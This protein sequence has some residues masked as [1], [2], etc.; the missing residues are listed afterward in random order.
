[1]RENV[2][3]GKLGEIGGLGEM[4]ERAKWEWRDPWQETLGSKESSN[5]TERNFKEPA[6]G[7][8]GYNVS[9]VGIILYRRLDVK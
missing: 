9:L 8:Q 5:L 7:Y 1:M 2:C 6:I 4:L 3:L